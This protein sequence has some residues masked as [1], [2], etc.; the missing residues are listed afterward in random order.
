[1]TIETFEKILND[2]INYMF[3][4]HDYIT[5]ATSVSFVNDIIL[6]N[7]LYLIKP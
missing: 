4:A 7:K 1:M 5:K 3:R 6:E 2:L